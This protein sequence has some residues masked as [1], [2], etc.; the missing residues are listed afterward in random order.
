VHSVLTAMLKPLLKPILCGGYLFTLSVAVADD[1]P[2][3]STVRMNL[4]TIGG[5]VN[6]AFLCLEYNGRKNHQVYDKRIE[7]EYKIRAYSFNAVFHDQP[8]IEIVAN[9]E[10]QSSAAARDGVLPIA[11]AM[12]RVYAPLRSGVGRIVLHRGNK[13]LHAGGYIEGY[14]QVVLYSDTVADRLA[15][16]HLE[17]SLFH[18]SV[19]AA[20]DRKY[21]GTELWRAAQLADDAFITQYA[22][23][24]GEDLAETALLVYGLHTNPDRI[25]PDVTEALATLVPNRTKAILSIMKREEKLRLNSAQVPYVIECKS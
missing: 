22:K 14:G 2:F 18:E 7:G 23:K 4:N 13:G 24:S 20:W 11:Y 3:R 21:A 8:P 10:F 15:A 17:E 6:S 19:H 9:P 1:A 25:P 16:N 12:G 5:A